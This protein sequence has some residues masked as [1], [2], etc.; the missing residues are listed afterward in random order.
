MQPPCGV[1]GVQR[2][3]ISNSET[4]ILAIT[5]FSFLRLQLRRRGSIP[6]QF[7]DSCSKSLTNISGTANMLDFSRLDRLCPS[8]KGGAL[9]AKCQ[10]I[11]IVPL[12]VSRRCLFGL[13]SCQVRHDKRAQ[14]QST[15]STKS[16]V[17]V[18]THY[19]KTKN[20]KYTSLILISDHN[21][22]A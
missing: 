17:A 9:T 1:A 12:R 10:L 11:R 13:R 21:S 8:E 15:G 5:G 14:P 6:T 22:S 3:P 16:L 4:A 18:Y 20:T 19:V 7:H 2:I